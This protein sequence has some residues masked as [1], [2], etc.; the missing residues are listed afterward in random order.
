MQE[1]LSVFGLPPLQHM[2]II[3]AMNKDAQ[4]IIKSNHATEDE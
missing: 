4:N 3:F 1:V 2:Y